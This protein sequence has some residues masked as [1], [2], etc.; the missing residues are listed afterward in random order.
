MTSLR[1]LLPLLLLALLMPMASV[2]Q[3]QTGDRV[4]NIAM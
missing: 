2:A 1:V 4:V 3:A